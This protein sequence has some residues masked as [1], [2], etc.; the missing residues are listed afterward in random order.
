VSSNDNGPIR[1][2][3]EGE[4]TLGWF[5]SFWHDWESLVQR[6]NWHDFC[7]VHLSGEWNRQFGRWELEVCLIGLWAKV[8]YV[9]DDS[10]VR[11]L[12]DKREDF[13]SRYTG[14]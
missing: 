6:C 4:R 8:E 9:Y 3:E 14:P 2:S 13:L 12:M 1:G 7:L 11:D 10:F 5:C